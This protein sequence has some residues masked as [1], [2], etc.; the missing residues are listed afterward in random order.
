MGIL[1]M[2]KKNN[3][4]H[5][6]AGAISG[7]L[8]RF[9]CQPLD[10][11]KI[12]FQL[13]VEPITRYHTSKYQSVFQAFWLILKEEGILALW[14]GHVPAQLLSI[15]YGTGQFYSYN[16][17]IAFSDKYS[18]LNERKYLT[19]FVAGASAGSIATIISFPFDTIRTR[20]IAQ[21]YNC[22]VYNGIL[23]SCSTILH[24]ETPKVFFAGLSPTLLQIAPHTGL[25]FL[26][27]RYLTDIYKK[28]FKETDINFYNSMISGS[29]A[30]LMAKTF[31][32]PMDLARK[33][34]QIQGFE[35]GRKEFGKFF[36]C[37]GLIDCLRVTIRDEGI[38]GLFK[39]LL[40]SQLKAAL[41]TALHFTF[42]EQ[43]LLVLKN[44]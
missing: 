21:S 27:Y 14:K 39:G 34:L 31:I 11:V 35:Y 18:Y 9:T 20:L 3:A 7:F 13:Q 17:I 19:N 16:V 2:D 22:K 4:N 30:G 36:K 40:P 8:T 5:A 44:I 25:Q 38:K 26:F 23:H 15:V 37:K 12:R 1:S 28:Y 10:V 42:Y 43:A 33:R 32:Y 6:I 41:T 29:I 24:Q